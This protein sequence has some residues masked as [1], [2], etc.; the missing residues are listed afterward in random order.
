MALPNQMNFP[1]STTFPKIH[2]IWYRHSSFTLI[3][4]WVWKILRSSL[5]LYRREVYSEQ[6]PYFGAYSLPTDLTYYLCLQ[7]QKTHTTGSS[8]CW[9]SSKTSSPRS[10]Q[11]MSS[12]TTRALT[13]SKWLGPDYPGQEPSPWRPRLHNFMEV[14]FFH[15][16]EWSKISLLFVRLVMKFDYKLQ[17]VSKL[18][19]GNN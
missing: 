8:P 18:N 4:I 11:R 17:Q 3:Q 14:K 15:E 19:S 1:K 13:R 7:L 2:P 9:S 12:S 5:R 6:I 16:T 10:T